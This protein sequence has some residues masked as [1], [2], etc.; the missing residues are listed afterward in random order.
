MD[1]VSELKLANKH[2]KVVILKKIV[3]ILILNYI[4]DLI[5]DRKEKYAYIYKK[6]FNL[7]N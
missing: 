6:Q 7:F 2:H 4:T 3:L 1:I 5:S